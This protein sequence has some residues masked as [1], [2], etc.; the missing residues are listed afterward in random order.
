MKTLSKNVIGTVYNSNRFDY[1]TSSKKFIADISEVR[2]VLRQLWIDSFDCGFGIR[3]VKTGE[4][5]LW[6]LKEIK[7]DNEGD[8]ICWI[9]EPYQP[10]PAVSECTVE[11][12]ND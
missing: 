11:I 4:I 9:F 3:S 5:V 1:L 8:I 6:T 12:L 10:T 7:K 2:C